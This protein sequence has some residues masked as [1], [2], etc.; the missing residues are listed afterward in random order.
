MVKQFKQ[1]SSTEN[2]MIV[3]G[4]NLAF[5]WFVSGKSQFSDEFVNTILS[6]AQS[7]KASKI[8][9]L[10]DGGSTFRYAKYP[11]YKS[12]RKLLRE[13]QSEEEAAKFKSFLSE[14]DKGLELIKATKATSIRYFGVEADDIAAYIVKEFSNQFPHTWLI[15]SD[16]DWDLLVNEK[17]SRWSYRTRK[18]TTAE[19]WHEHYL[20]DRE[21]YLDF[22]VL[23]GDKSDDIPG[24]E[25]IAEKRACVL[26]KEYGSVLDIY[27]QLPIISKLKYIQNLNNF[28][29][30]ILRNL[31]LMDLITYCEEA[32]G[33]SNL[34][35][36]D[37][38][39]EEY[40]NA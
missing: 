18:E 40:F 8:I 16:R 23:T 32:I 3:D 4:L 5:R 14:V 19:N 37:N 38:T 11:E 28:G 27:D 26:I 1:I 25:G 31:E 15:S 12:S 29:D 10:G 24:V 22:K 36:L 7:Y 34:E 9:V 39:L 35:K 30:G 2:L 21:N 33:D 17:V 6:I 13:N 20:V